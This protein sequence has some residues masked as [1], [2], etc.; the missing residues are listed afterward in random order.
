MAVEQ[1]L[2]QGVEQVVETR[3]MV[4]RYGDMVA[5]DNASLTVR[6]GEIFGL[7]GPNGA[8][9]TT[10]IKVLLGLL[11][12]D[13]GEVELFGERFRGDELSLKAR[14]GVVP[15]HL[16]ILEDLSAEENLRFFGRLYGVRGELLSR[17]VGEAL[18]F[19]GLSERRR[20]LPKKFSGGMKRRLNIAAALVH[21]PE[22]LIMDEPTV[23]I[24]PQS[25]NHILES[26]RALREGGMTIVYT[27]HYM[28]EVSSICDRIVILDHGRVIASGSEE[29]L[30]RF[31]E[32]EE[33]ISLSLNRV[34]PAVVEELEKMPGVVQCEQNEREIVLMAGANQLRLSRLI[35]QVSAHGCEVL[36][37]NVE[38]PTLESVFLTLTGR[39][40]RD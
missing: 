6:S 21:Q 26:V 8:G 9:K 28:E 1:A 25:R 7:L 30:V 3:N 33:R 29:E 4:K 17:R 38:R 18:D 37:A 13:S 32:R 14:M 16:A 31:V 20:E 22:L 40:L 12:P 5:V 34:F 15:Q 36:S 23:G 35:E 24:D 11:S 10:A 19:V 39:S 2:E 27:S